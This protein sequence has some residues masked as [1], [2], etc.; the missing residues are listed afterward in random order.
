[1]DILYTVSFGISPN[2]FIP[3]CTGPVEPD[4][5]LAPYLF[6]CTDFE[7]EPDCVEGAVFS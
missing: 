3:L 6:L 2:E 4:I 5:G 1:M 7:G